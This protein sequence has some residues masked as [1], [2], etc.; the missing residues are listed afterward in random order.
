[1]CSNRKTI[2]GERLGQLSALG[3]VV[4]FTWK[5]CLRLRE[6]GHSL[7]GSLVE[8]NSE[9]S[10]Q[11]ISCQV[12]QS[13]QDFCPQTSDLSARSQEELHIPTSN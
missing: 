8:S 10:W 12:K 7:A 9:V 6:S 13:H 5:K 1:M 11:L 3:G 2:D 4:I